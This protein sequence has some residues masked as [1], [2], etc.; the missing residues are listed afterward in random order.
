LGKRPEAEGQLRKAQALLEELAAASPAVP[1]YRQDLANSYHSLGMLLREQG[2]RPEAEGQ[3][4]KALAL[5]QK[6]AADF[7]AVPAYQIDLGGGYSNYGNLVTASGRP[8]ESLGWFNKAIRILTT[9]YE[10]DRQAMDARQALRNSH[11]GRAVAYEFLRKYAEAIEDWDRAVALSPTAEQPRFRAKLAAARLNAGQVA[12]ALAEVG[13]V[14]KLPG[15]PEDAPAYNDLGNALLGKGRVDEAIACFRKALAFAP[16]HARAHNYLGAALVR[17]GQVDAAI[18]S[19]RKATA[20]DPKYA[21][22]TSTWALRWGPGARWMR[23]SPASGRASNSSPGTPRPTAPWAPCSA[24][25]KGITTGP[26]NAS[27]TPS[28]L[29]R[30]TPRTTSA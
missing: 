26:S 8:S 24:T 11:V 4:R 1:Q 3:L 18:S 17:K 7:P 9:P 19:W 5:W 23:P 30:S 15:H 14:L 27:A 20:L 29:T 28:P 10:R 13:E 22:P 21:P 6:L 12:E 2:K 25:S 16:K